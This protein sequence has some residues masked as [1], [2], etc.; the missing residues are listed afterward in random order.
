FRTRLATAVGRTRAPL[1]E[2]L[3]IAP[4][5]R[6]R[7]LTRAAQPL[8]QHGVT[9]DGLLDADAATRVARGTLLPTMERETLLRHGDHATL[10]RPWYA[11]FLVARPKFNAQ[12]LDASMSPPPTPERLVRQL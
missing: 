6:P 7:R 5:D 2:R 8:Q 1:A 9:F 3:F 10:A 4:N 12:L 11:S